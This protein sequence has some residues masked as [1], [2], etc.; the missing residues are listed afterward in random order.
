VTP[1]CAKAVG[2]SG[3][4]NAMIYLRGTITDF[5]A[6]N[7]WIG[8]W[9][10]YSQLLKYYVKPENNT[11]FGHSSAYHGHSGNVHISHNLNHSVDPL[12]AAFTASCSLDGHSI[13][14]DFNVPDRPIN[15][16]GDYQFLIDHSGPQTIRDSVARAFYRNAVRPSE[17]TVRSQS[18]VI[19]IVFEE[20][21]AV[22]VR[23]VDF[24]KDSSKVQ[25]VRVTKEVVLSAGTLNTPTILMQSGI[26]DS[27][28]LINKFGFKP[29]EVVLD[30]AEIGRNYIDGVFTFM[31]WNVTDDLMGS[32]AVCTPW[33]T[34]SKCR[35]QWDRYMDDAGGQS[36]FDSTGFNVGGFFQSPFST[37]N[38]S[39]RSSNDLQITLQPFDIV[40][41]VATN[42]SNVVTA[43][44][45]LNLPQSKGYLTWSHLNNA[46]DVANL[47]VDGTNIS[48]NGNYLD[49]STDDANALMF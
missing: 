30:N 45:A 28:T 8:Q 42:S 35:E 27:E 6:S 4:I 7:G 36:L 46:E 15:V 21:R 41:Q 13:T 29:S 43:Q 47:V 44:I 18:T 48:V 16:C 24:G 32:F 22:R 2:G 19:D 31:Q 34:S 12:S 33:T 26:G 23:F 14:D 49:P 11:D 17:L 37:S 1:S 9:A 5:T 39:N 40:G 20:K 10:N 3:A 25:S 38:E